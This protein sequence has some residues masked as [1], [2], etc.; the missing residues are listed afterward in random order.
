MDPTLERDPADDQVAAFLD[1]TVGELAE[2]NRIQPPLGR[3]LAIDRSGPIGL[4]TAVVRADDRLFVTHRVTEESSYGPLL[5][6]AVDDLITTHPSI[7]VTVTTDQSDRRRTAERLGFTVELRGSAFAI[8]FASAL[9]ATTIAAARSDR[10]EVVPAD[11]VDPDALFRLDTALRQDVPG[12]DGWRGNRL[13]FDDELA[14]DEF[15][16]AAYPVARDR[17][18]GQLVGLCRIWRNPSG[19]SLGLVGVLPPYRTGRPALVLLHTAL[20][21]AGRWGWSTFEAHT[22]RGALQRRATALGAEPTGGF[23]RLRRDGSP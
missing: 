3:W 9:A 6:A 17:S 10:I 1:V 23:V 14:S 21:A 15:E 4:A 11:R 18:T 7:H 12:N 8:P 2:R 16:P 20:T 13:W 19:P 22:A 5:A